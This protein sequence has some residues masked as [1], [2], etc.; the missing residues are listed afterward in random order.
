MM[1]TLRQ[2]FLFMGLILSSVTFAA[3]YQD[4]MD[5][6]KAAF[7]RGNFEFAV[8]Y[9]NEAL[10]QLS[11]KYKPAQYI[12]T[13][14]R[15]AAAYQSLGRLK[16]A[17]DILESLLPLVKNAPKRKANVLM[18]LSNVYL[19]MRDFKDK[20]MSC[21]VKTSSTTSE[22]FL[23]RAQESIEKAK[24][25][26]NDQ[27]LLANI[28]NTKGNVL[29]AQKK[30]VEALSAYKESVKLANEGNDNALS[31]KASF[32]I[33]HALMKQQKIMNKSNLNLLQLKNK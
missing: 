31:A 6:G 23:E 1:K 19:A 20:D 10:S 9:W 30:Y 24:A 32:N 16:E 29:M 5:Q 4:A 25:E 22:N 21:E 3:S 14:V 7:Q 27:L 12:D 8:Q 26:A 15:L 13:S 28:L 11:S 17:C 18:Q 2:F 33:V